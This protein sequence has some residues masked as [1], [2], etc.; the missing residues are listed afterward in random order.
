MSNKREKRPDLLEK[1]LDALAHDFDR[2][3]KLMME[4]RRKDEH[5]TKRQYG[6]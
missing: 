5:R 3:Y 1:T 6:V 4:E 2:D